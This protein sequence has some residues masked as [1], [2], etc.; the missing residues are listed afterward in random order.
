[1]RCLIIGTSNSVMKAGY[2]PHLEALCPDIAFRL[3][4]I[5]A[6]PSVLLPYA[7]A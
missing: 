5:G 6:T 7:L 4:T 1:L 2:R 3:F